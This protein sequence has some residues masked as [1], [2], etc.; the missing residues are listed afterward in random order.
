MLEGVVKRGTAAGQV[1]LDRPVAGKTGTTNDEKDA[2]FVGYTPN[3]V[4]GVY[5]GYDNPTPMGHGETGGVL[6]APVFNDFM[7][8]ALEG[9]PPADFRKPEGIQMIAIDRKTGMAPPPGDKDVIEEA[10][11]PGMGRPR[12]IRS[13]E[14]ATEWQAARRSPTSRRRPRAP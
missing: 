1:E 13:S 14:S 3:L 11:K 10:F 4:A 2:W 12:P 9:V 6:A 7:K 5:I 8:A